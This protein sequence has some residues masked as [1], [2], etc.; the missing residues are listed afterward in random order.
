[1]Y[2]SFFFVREFHNKSAA[3]TLLAFDLNKSLVSLHN[4]VLRNSILIHNP[5]HC[6]DHVMAHGKF[7]KYSALV[8]RRN[9]NTLVG[10][11]EIDVLVVCY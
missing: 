4:M 7:V 3:L 10:Y 2:N 5:L 1:M 6:D 11:F 8:F 9:A